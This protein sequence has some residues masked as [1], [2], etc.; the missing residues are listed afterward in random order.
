MYQVKADGKVYEPD[1][2]VKTP[3][4]T[5]RHFR[6]VVVARMLEQYFS[7][8]VETALLPAGEPWILLER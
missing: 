3:F 7:A 4:A 2:S 1:V 8:E 6:R 5:V